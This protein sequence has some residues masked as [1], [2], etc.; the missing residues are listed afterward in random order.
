MSSNGFRCFDKRTPERLIRR[1][2]VERAATV[3]LELLKTGNVEPAFTVPY[4]TALVMV[5]DE[6]EHVRT[7][8]V[9]PVPT[10]RSRSSSPSWLLL[11]FECSAQQ[12]PRES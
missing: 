8:P 7:V 10:S 11:L 4:A 12:V 1:V 5:A 3:Q 6:R 9:D 2:G